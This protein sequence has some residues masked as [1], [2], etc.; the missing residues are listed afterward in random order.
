MNLKRSGLLRTT[1][2]IIAGPLPRNAACR[3]AGTPEPTTAARYDAA[4][5]G[6]S[7]TPAARSTSLLG[8]QMPAPDLAAEPPKTGAFSTTRV[9]RPRLAAASAA[10]MPAAPAPTTTTS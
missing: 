7:G 9:L 8:I 1:N 4:L 3:P 2:E 10:V 6:E 5:D